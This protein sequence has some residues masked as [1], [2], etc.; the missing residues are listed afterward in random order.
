[1]TDYRTRLAKS[2]VDAINKLHISLNEQ[3]Y[4]I[5]KNTEAI[6]E[7]TKEHAKQGESA[8]P[9]SVD[10]NK[11]VA[12]TIQGEATA[13]V[14]NSW[15]WRDYTR[16]GLEGIGLAVLI[17]YA[18]TTN[19]LLRESRTTNTLTGSALKETHE[20]FQKDQR[21]YV[22]IANNKSGMPTLTS[23]IEKPRFFQA[24]WDIGISNFGKT[25]AYHVRRE[26]FIQVGNKHP[27]VRSYGEKDTDAPAIIAP[28]G[29]VTI[30]VLSSPDIVQAEIGDIL[31]PHSGQTITIRGT[32]TYADSYGTGYDSTIC[33]SRIDSG[34]VQY[35]EGNDTK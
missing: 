9:I 22:W 18:C 32:I 27:S 15:D 12:V 6:Q 26:F 24:V 7:A 4:A 19:G 2:F 28:T 1:M 8:R 10:P 14:E 17:W 23:L 3:V 31:K 34:S 33:L 21:P 16:F 29:E 5:R 25:P 35:C 11:P 13:K 20:N 30:R